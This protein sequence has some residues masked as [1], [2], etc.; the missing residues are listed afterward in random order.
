MEEIKKEKAER[1]QP[2]AL[3]FFL[4]S[5]SLIVLSFWVIWFE[6][7]ELRPWKDYQKTYYQLKLE[8]YEK[9]YDE[10]VARFNSPEIQVKY[11]S[12]LALHKKNQKTFRSPEIQ[13]QYL[14]AQTELTDIHTARKSNMAEFRD[15]R[16]H[17][18]ETEYLY[19]KH[20]RETDKTELDRLDQIII[21][22]ESENQKLA[23]QEENL[24]SRLM[25]FTGD[26]ERTTS[27][28]EALQTP[29]NQAK[30]RIRILNEN[31]IEI[32][33]VYLPDI[34]KADRCQSCHIGIDSRDNIS[35]QQPF[36]SHP[37]SHIFLDNH[38][39]A[40]FGCT[41]CHRG[42][43]RAISSENKAH[44]WV[45]HWLEPMVKGNMIQA[46]C[47]G[48]HGDF[49][50]L[51]GADL[52]AKGSDIVEKYGCYGCHTIA[53]Y[54]DLRKVGPDL[55]DVG[56]KVNYSWLVEWI[57][58]PKNYLSQARMPKFF[59]SQQEAEAI[60]DYLF[61]MTLQKRYD[62]Q[63]DDIDWDLADQ[64]KAVWR[65][66]RCS[67]CHAVNGVGGN[68]E[69]IFSPDLGQVGTKVNH[70][71]L[72]DW[73]KD[74]KDYF[75]KTKMPRFRL[76]DDK[77]KA[78]V[79][80][81]RSEYID[82]DF[83]PLYAQP[84]PID[85]KSIERGKELIQNY[86]CFGCHNVKG[87]E[88]MERIGPYLRSKEVA[89]LKI[90]EVDE[91][92][93]S[94][95]S[96]IGSKA[97]EQLDFGKMADKLPKDRV[98]YM[99]HKLR[100]PRSFRDNLRMPNFRFSE[101]EIDALVTLLV[102]FT[103][104]NIPTRFKVPKKPVNYEPTGE[105]ARI[106]D[107]V[108]CLNCHTIKGNGSDFA[109]DLSIEGS[110][111]QEQWLRAFLKQPDIIRPML[112]QMPLFYL[113]HE[114]QM[115]QGNLTY[116]EIEII[117]QYIKSVLVTNEIPESIPENGLIRQKQIETGKRIYDEKGCRTCHQIG[118]DGGAVG[119]SLTSVGNRLKEEYI[120]IYLKN[121]QALIPDI[122]EPNYG[123]TEEERVNLTRYLM[124]LNQEQ[125]F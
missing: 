79:E 6:T 21:Q 40:E 121:P 58:D 11:E 68:H 24:S 67:I 95:L 30:D 77:L 72:R 5:A 115:I 124:S 41:F 82:W 104:A 71:W 54:N 1:E 120:F 38:P 101:E 88:E 33:Q 84:V 98:S 31:P 70:G 110:K 85:I 100:D 47:E 45:E 26:L 123:F 107:D 23:I 117:V 103:D 111:V 10:A 64:G 13:A 8:K 53:G 102:G 81:I 43:G 29:I 97:L 42:Q 74:P 49:K 118:S 48:C 87:M 15:A 44:G 51:Q 62:E 17:Y 116:T 78:L 34:N 109:P 125:T 61:S 56:T 37:A 105:F 65:N 57:K 20:Q 14:N 28:L 112:Q 89:Y 119:P 73:I 9:E 96:S 46:S 93:G 4:L 35:E 50:Q 25:K 19:Y 114:Q 32:K 55:T 90:A 113:D 27:E 12:L 91:K 22:I 2:Y 75:P 86:G 16:G 106:V 3:Y 7:V 63:S 94:E 76:S 122:V 83:E 99:Q 60:A 92:I 69:K 39:P 18:L 66:S 36:T 108:K 59:F 52:I 80:Y